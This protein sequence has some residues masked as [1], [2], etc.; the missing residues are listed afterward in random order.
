MA[1]ME[2]FSKI[3]AK[4]NIKQERPI[5]GKLKMAKSTAQAS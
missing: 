4:F 2:N 1:L 3:Y 5:K